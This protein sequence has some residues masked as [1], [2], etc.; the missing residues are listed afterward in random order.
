MELTM[1]PAGPGLSKVSSW[2]YHCQ[3]PEQEI[4]A[5]IKSL[6][7]SLRALKQRRKSR[8]MFSIISVADLND[9]LFRCNLQLQEPV[10]MTMPLWMLQVHVAFKLWLRSGHPVELHVSLLCRICNHKHGGTV[11]EWQGGIPVENSSRTVIS[12]F[13]M[14]PFCPYF[15]IWSIQR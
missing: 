9:L 11:A 14:L 1:N 12:E 6:E 5:E 4:D 2:Q 15:C 10:P 3:H 13:R 7:E 8:D